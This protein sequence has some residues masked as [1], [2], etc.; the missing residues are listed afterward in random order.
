MRWL[1]AALLLS[2]TPV[3]AQDWAFR[4]GDLALD[5]AAVSDQIVGRVL[6]FYDDGQSRHDAGGAY[7]YTYSLENGGGTAFGTFEVAEDGVVCIGFR[8]GFSRCDRY[9]LN[10]SRL[11]LL[12]EDGQRFPVRP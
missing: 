6:V 10:G 9:V 8:H 1:L 11:V 5:G 2:A 3:T 7:S 12:T 4:D